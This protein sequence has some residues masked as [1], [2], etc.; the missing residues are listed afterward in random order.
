VRRV[1]GRGVGEAGEQVAEHGAFG[2]VERGEEVEPVLTRCSPTSRSRAPL[3]HPGDEDRRASGRALAPVRTR[4]RPPPGAGHSDL[5]VEHVVLITRGRP[6]D[7]DAV[8][9]VAAA[10]GS[11]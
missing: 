6:W 4:R 2:V 11:S 10:G 8:A 3:A 5:G 9:T 7:A 1:P